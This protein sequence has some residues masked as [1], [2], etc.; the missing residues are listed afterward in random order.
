MGFVQVIE[1]R[2]SKLEEMNRLGAEWEAAAGND[3]KSERRVLCKDRDDDGRFFNIVF[4]DSYDAAMENDD[5]HPDCRLLI[6]TEL[7]P[8]CAAHVTR[9]NALL[10]GLTH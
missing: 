2:T 3:S 7:L 8:A 1:F 10:G 5:L 9:L 6:S 4:F